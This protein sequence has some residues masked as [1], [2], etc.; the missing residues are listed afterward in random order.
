MDGL[1]HDS[2]AVSSCPEPVTLL[3]FTEKDGMKARKEGEKQGRSIGVICNPFVFI[4]S[5]LGSS[6]RPKDLGS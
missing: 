2:L 6:P 3:L 4:S 1:V 5:R